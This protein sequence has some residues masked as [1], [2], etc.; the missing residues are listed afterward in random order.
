MLDLRLDGRAEVQ[1]RLQATRLSSFRGGPRNRTSVYDPVSALSR[2]AFSPPFGAP[3]AAGDLAGYRRKRPRRPPR[4]R[5]IVVL[6]GG[7]AVAGSSAVVAVAAGAPTAAGSA[8]RS[9]SRTA[10]RSKRPVRGRLVAGAAALVSS[11]SRAARSVRRP[12]ARPA[13]P[14]MAAPTP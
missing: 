14:M 11:T 10:G 7:T 4:R 6:A 12:S 8:T 5:L 1:W 13:N 3:V 9:S 2:S